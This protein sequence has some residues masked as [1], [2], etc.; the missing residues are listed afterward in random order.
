MR[1]VFC[2]F[3]CS[4]ACVRNAVSGVCPGIWHSPGFNWAGREMGQDWDIRVGL[5]EEK[6]LLASLISF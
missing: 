5:A 1:T 3:D 6:F 4:L 2:N